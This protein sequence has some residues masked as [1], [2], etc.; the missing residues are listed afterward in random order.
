MRLSNEFIK[1]DWGK[2]QANAHN[3]MVLDI[4]HLGYSDDTDAFETGVYVVNLYN[5]LRMVNSFFANAGIEKNIETS[6]LGEMLNSFYTGKPFTDEKLEEMVILHNKI[7]A[8]A[9]SMHH[10]S[11]LLM[12]NAYIP[13]SVIM[14]LIGFNHCKQQKLS[15]IGKLGETEEEFYKLGERLFEGEIT[16]KEFR[17]LGLDML[18]TQ[19]SSVS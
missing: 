16:V 11:P 4:E 2:I 13:T 1:K 9:R 18:N 7:E 8:L 15:D 14:S 19:S 3:Y 12:E 17:K 5:T 10:I 6:I